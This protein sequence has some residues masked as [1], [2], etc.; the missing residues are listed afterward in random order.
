MPPLLFLVTRLASHPT[1]ATASEIF[2]GPATQGRPF[3]VSATS[4]RLISFVALTTVKLFVS[5]FLRKVCVIFTCTHTAPRQVSGKR[6]PLW[7]WCIL[8]KHPG[9]SLAFSSGG[10]WLK[11]IPGGNRYYWEEG[12]GVWRG[13]DLAL[14][15]RQASL[16]G[17]DFVK[18][19]ACSSFMEAAQ[20]VTHLKGTVGYTSPRCSFRLFPSPQRAHRRHSFGLGP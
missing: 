12:G 18:K 8:G 2:P 13:G 3:L 20:T 6:Q 1:Q 14:G 17:G 19:D 5:V 16:G 15:R 9:S 11:Q 10:D 4:T 7:A